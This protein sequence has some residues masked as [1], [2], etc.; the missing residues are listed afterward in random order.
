MA[1]LIEFKS[2]EAELFEALSVI[3]FTADQPNPSELKESIKAEDIF[4]KFGVP[5]TESKFRTVDCPHCR[6]RM[7]QMPRI[8]TLT[9]PVDI[10]VEDKVLDYI[11]SRFDK[12]QVIGDNK[13]KRPFVQLRERFEDVKKSKLDDYDKI[14][15]YIKQRDAAVPVQAYS[16]ENAVLE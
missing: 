5:A 4:E 10:I 13:M 11:Q 12:W 14:Q 16:S 9:G 6:Q 15:A 1:K 3:F 7:F 2:N 8:Y